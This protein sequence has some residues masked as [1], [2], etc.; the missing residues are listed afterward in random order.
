MMHHTWEL[1]PSLPPPPP[2]SLLPALDSLP[3]VYFLF[4]SLFLPSPIP[5]FPSILDGAENEFR[6]E[7]LNQRWT[8]GERISSCETTKSLQSRRIKRFQLVSVSVGGVHVGKSHV[9][10][11]V[12]GGPPAGTKP[13]SAGLAINVEP[14]QGPTGAQGAEQR[15]D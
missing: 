5:H 14:L 4:S 2:C 8:R 3:D 9:G 10:V 12:G 1:P 15:Q 13:L 7:L 11:G 6:G